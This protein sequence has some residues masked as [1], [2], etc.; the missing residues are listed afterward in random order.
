MKR[1]LA[2]A[3]ESYYP[4]G[5]KGDFIGDFDTLEA[6]SSQKASNDF[7]DVLDTSTGEWMEFVREGLHARKLTGKWVRVT[8]T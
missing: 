2:F 4:S 3:Y 1:F 7:L 8:G 6:V 5:G